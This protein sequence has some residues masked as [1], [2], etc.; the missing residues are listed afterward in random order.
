MRDRLKSLFQTVHDRLRGPLSRVWSAPRAG[1]PA[2]TST[3]P[4]LDELNE[5]FHAAYGR[6]REAAHSEGPVFVVVADQLILFRAEERHAFSFSPRAFHVIKS[7]AHVPV[8][9][10]TLWRQPEAITHGVIRQLRGRI[11]ATQDDISREELQQS[12]RAEL[13]AV[14]A[15]CAELIDAADDDGPSVVQ[16]DAFAEALR[17]PLLRLV[18]E[19]TEL[20]L[21]A[22][23]AHTQRA[24]AMLSQAEKEQLHVVVAGDH[25]ARVRSLPMQYFQKQLA[26]LHGADQ[27]LTYAEGVRDERGALQLVGTQRVDRELAR[28]FFGNERRMQRDILGDAAEEILAS[29]DMGGASSPGAPDT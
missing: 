4:P 14:L 3:T 21:A 17:G 15:A 13:R 28:A 9:L 2:V 26:H 12:T 5:R 10:Y 8:L 20:Q 22:L 1:A 29:F 19:A 25:Q 18:H 23:H 6:E 7:V 24:L 16:R 27:R 11:S